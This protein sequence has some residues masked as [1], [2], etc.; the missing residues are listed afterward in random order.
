[1]LK[2]SADER[3]ILSLDTEITNAKGFYHSDGSRVDPG[4]HT[5]CIER[6]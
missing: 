1:M 2:R 4:N 6:G 5:A 3:L